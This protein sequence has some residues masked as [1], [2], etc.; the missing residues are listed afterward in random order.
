[1]V[2]LLHWINYT[3]DVTG[4]LHWGWC[5]W[6]KGNPFG[7]PSERLPPGDCNTVYPGPDGPLNSLRWETQR[8]SLEDFE[9]LWLL[10]DRMRAVKEKLG[11]AARDFDPAERSKEF[12][13]RLIHDFADVE[14]DSKL[15]GET[16]K[17]IAAEIIAAGQDPPVILTTRP[18]EW[19]ELVPGP[20]AVEIHGAVQPGTVIQG[21]NVQIEPNG[22][23]RGLAF[24][25]G[26]RNSIELTVKKDGK[27]KK[28]V[29]RFRVRGAE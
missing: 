11:D 13:R 10:T 1:M 22:R 5:A 17:A 24:L 18:P 16:R 29:R 15:I 23:F 8:D 14:A 19:M 9:Y 12:C 27:E 6:P 28:L 4:Y 26:K 3:Y 21:G 20:I 2:R 7:T 25:S